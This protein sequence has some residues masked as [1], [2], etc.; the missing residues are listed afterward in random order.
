MK[1]F[2]STSFDKWTL[3]FFSLLVCILDSKLLSQVLFN[4]SSLF[5]IGCWWKV[6][7]ITCFRNF[8]RWLCHICLFRDL[9]SFYTL[10]LQLYFP[11]LMF[12][13][14][15][16]LQNK[17]MWHTYA[18]SDVLL[19]SAWTGSKN[20]WIDDSQLLTF[21]ARSSWTFS[22]CLKRSVCYLFRY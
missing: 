12:Y 2:V 13:K 8:S 5:P 21:L 9:C 3:C 7:F 19:S 15:T 14:S 20:S 16:V 17:V 6:Y 4:K 22:K 18:K 11:S 10:K 1:I